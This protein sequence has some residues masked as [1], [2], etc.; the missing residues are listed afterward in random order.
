MLSG[1]KFYNSTTRSFFEMGDARFLEDVEFGGED[2]VR[3]VAFE[4]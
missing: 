3:S 1:F 4:E 2:K